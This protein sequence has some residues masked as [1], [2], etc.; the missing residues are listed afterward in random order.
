ML[1]LLNRPMFVF[2][3]D[4]A[5]EII[6]TDIPTTIPTRE[7]LIVYVCSSIMLEIIFAAILLC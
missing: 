2:L 4:D 7:G 5:S 6:P 3:D 1:K